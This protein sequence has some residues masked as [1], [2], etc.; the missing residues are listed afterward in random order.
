MVEWLLIS[1]GLAGAELA[2]IANEAA[3]SA[4]RRGSQNLIE[5]DFLVSICGCHLPGLCHIKPLTNNFEWQQHRNVWASPDYVTKKFI[6]IY[7]YL[8]AFLDVASFP[9]HGSTIEYLFV[10]LTL[11]LHPKF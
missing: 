4:A 3:I 2:T 1:T 11:T 7:I 5:A 8:K 9:F 10:L 6:Y